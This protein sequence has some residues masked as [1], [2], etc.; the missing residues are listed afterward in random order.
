MV[1]PVAVGPAAARPEPGTGAV[2]PEPEPV[3]ARASAERELEPVLP[4]AE[5]EPVAPER[6][7]VAVASIVDF[8]SVRSGERP[9]VGV[10]AGV[11][12]PRIVAGLVDEA[13]GRSGDE[14]LAAAEA[15][16]QA[17]NDDSLRSLLLWTARAYAREGRFEAGLDATHRLL[18]RSPSD[19]DAHLVL[20]EL[21][22]ARGWD[23]LAAD[24]LRLLGRLAELNHD[25]ET[26]R[27]LCDAATRA[28]PQDP[29]LEHLCA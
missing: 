5:P 25:E 22:V 3:A 24:K 15:A 7:P 6:E 10:M 11:D 16:D 18:Q 21:Y 17:G 23:G 9:P 28:F 2:E 12:G 27:R 1:E 13:D 20:V 26:R 19:V 8:P 29:T 14:L 4:E